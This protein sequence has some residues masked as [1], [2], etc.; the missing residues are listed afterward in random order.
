MLRAAKRAGSDL[1]QRVAPIMDRGGLVSDELM[2]EVVND[3][4][5]AD[6]CAGGYLLDGFPRTIPQAQALQDFLEN[7]QTP[8]DHVIEIH[9]DDEELVRRL[10]LRQKESG[11]NRADDT[12]EAIPHRLQV[13]HS[14]TAP[15]LEFYQQVGGVLKTIDGLGSVDDVFE[16]IVKAI[17]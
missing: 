13:Y 16:R 5:S 1:G 9:V 15:L 10:L 11:Q 12:P 6:D 4:I 7:K 2:V 17:S 3:R 14:Q 8:L